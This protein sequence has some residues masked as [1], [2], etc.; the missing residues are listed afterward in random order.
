M[1]Q[2]KLKRN[3]T[4]RVEKLKEGMWFKY[5]LSP[6]SEDLAVDDSLRGLLRL[7]PAYCYVSGTQW[8]DNPEIVLATVD[9]GKKR[10]GIILR[11]TE[12]VPL[13]KEV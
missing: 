6:T 7:S 8:L 10:G 9:M 2:P 5:Q 4:I 11:R 1:K 12:L 3:G 13:F